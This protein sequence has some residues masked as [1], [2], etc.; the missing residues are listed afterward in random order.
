MPEPKYQWYEIVEG[1]GLQ[2]GDILEDV[3]I[4]TAMPRHEGQDDT[5]PSIA[6]K[7][8]VVII[9][10]SCDILK[11]QC[12]NIVVCPVWSLADTKK[13]IPHFSSLDGLEDLRQGRVV[14]YHILNRCDIQE[15]QKDFRIVN[16]YRIFELPKSRAV[17]IAYAQS[18]RL[19]LLP[20]YRE[21]LS[22]AFARF[23]MRVGLPVEIP[24]F[25]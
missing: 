1:I 16:F 22:Q 20:P 2:Q 12:Q 7:F 23:F 19:R 13:N 3:D 4:Y 10:Q 21:H 25:T 15:F 14:G 24:K 9:T 6:D 18:P 11:E 8:D 5:V 17:S